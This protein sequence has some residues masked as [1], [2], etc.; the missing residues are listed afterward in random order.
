MNESIER[1]TFLRATAAATATAVSVAA[2][3]AIASAAASKP[4]LLGGEPIRKAGWPSWPV[5]DASEEERCLDAFRK[6]GWFRFAGASNYVGEFEKAYAETMGVKHCL[7]V[8]NGTSALISSLNALE[9]GP[10]DEVIVPPYTFSAT[11]NVVLLQFALPVFVDTDRET[12][13]MDA[14][15]LEAAITDRTRCIIP[16]HLGG[17][18]V[19]MDAVMGV[20]ALRGIPIVEDA[21]QSHLAEWRGKRVGS[22]GNTGCFSFQVTKNLSCGDGGAMLTND[23]AV[24]EAAYS[25]HSNGRHIKRGSSFAYA[26]SGSNVRMTEFQG[27]LLLGQ[28][29]RLE[30]QSRTREQNAQHLTT[31]LKEIPGIHPARMYEGCTRNAYHLYMFRYD[32]EQ[33][34]GMSRARF[35]QALNAEGVPCSSGY[36]P[37][38]SEPYISERLHSRPYVNTYGKER[39]EQHC[40]AMVCP[41]ND[42]LC[43]EAVWFTQNMLLAEREAMDEIADAIEKIHASAKELAA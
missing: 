32:S 15:K 40:A 18:S 30:E 8:A 4:A 1:R 6:K 5:F 13:Q 22:Y 42:R 9:I 11:I 37:M 26:R 14:R 29:A 36:K 23:D 7:A 12:F 20:A 3:P 21:C 10:G 35:L 17:A 2:G 33:F 28:L 39:I 24:Y 19:D 16:V 34:A 25:F 31:R 41:E 27:A 38:T 43:E